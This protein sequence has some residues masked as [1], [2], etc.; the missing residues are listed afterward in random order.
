MKLA[1]TLVSGFT[2][3][4]LMVVV[5]IAGILA[6]I[7]IPGFQSLTRSQ[8]VKNAS[9]DLYA[10]L[11]LARSEAIKRNSNVVLTPVDY[12][13][14]TPSA[15]N[16]VGWNIVAT[17][18]TVPTA[19]DTTIFNQSQLKGIALS[20]VNITYQRTG[21]T[22]AAASTAFLIDSYGATTTSARCVRI[23]LNGMPR[24]YKKPSS[25]TC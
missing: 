5:V 2:L 6:T 20:L 12:S 14:T 24:I 17:N 7:A 10:S 23:E 25:G 3:I 22:T 21:R 4:E 8:Q 13:V 15:H 19:D 9:F 1:P 11:S 16:E 18:G